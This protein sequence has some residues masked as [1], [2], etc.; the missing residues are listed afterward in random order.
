MKRLFALFALLAVSLPT[1]LTA[2]SSMP[3][4]PYAYTQLEDPAQEQIARDLMET[5][6]CLQCQSQSIADSD[7][8]VAGDMRHQVRTRIAAGESPEEIR[9]YLISRY[10]DYIS[11]E[12]EISATTWPLFV[13]PGILVLLALIVLLRRVGRVRE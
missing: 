13:L 10:G 3:P 11:Y 7:A 5:L 8:P 2:Q 6:R 1:A 9:A 12:P 4:A